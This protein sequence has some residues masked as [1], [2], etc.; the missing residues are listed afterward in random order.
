MGESPRPYLYTI[1]SLDQLFCV[2][3][4]NCSMQ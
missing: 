3:K 4:Y 1:Q 2:W